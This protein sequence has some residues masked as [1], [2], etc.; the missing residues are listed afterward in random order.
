MKRDINPIFKAANL[1]FRSPPVQRRRTDELVI[2]HWHSETATVRDVHRWH[3]NAGKIGIGYNL[4]IMLNGDVWIGR[5]VDTVGAHTL[6]HNSRSVGIGFQGR[7]DDRTTSMPDAQFNAG[8]SVL[9]YLRSR[10]GDL[11]MFG[12]GELSATA[13]P[14]RFFPLDEMRTLR[15]RS[16]F[17]EDDMERIKALED[18]IGTLAD[19]VNDLTATVAAI[20]PTFNRSSDMPEWMHEAHLDSVERGIISG[21]V[22]VEGDREDAVFMT[23]LSPIEARLNVMADRRERNPRTD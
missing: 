4:C 16:D 7:Y 10:Y 22:L 6:Y 14:G 20:R 1:S 8:V 21:A 19:R 17:E 13:C 9:H 15:Y 18:Q 3:L 23:P 5:G 2:H 11:P 12:H